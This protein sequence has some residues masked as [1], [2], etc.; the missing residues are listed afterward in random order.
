MNEEVRLLVGSGAVLGQQSMRLA[1]LYSVMELRETGVSV[2][3]RST[4][5]VCMR[6]R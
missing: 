4:F 2:V 6:C 3:E 1:V 5:H